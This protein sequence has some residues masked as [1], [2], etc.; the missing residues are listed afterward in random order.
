MDGGGS[1]PVA[2]LGQDGVGVVVPHRLCGDAVEQL[3]AAREQ[4]LQVI[5]QLGHGAHGGARAADRVGLV[6]SDGRRHAV[7]TVHRRFV[8]AVQELAGVGAESLDVT[9][10]AFGKQSVEH[11][12]GLAR[13]TGAGDHRQLAGADVQVHALQVVLAGTADANEAMTIVAKV[14]GMGLANRDWT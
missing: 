2:Q 4:Q 11:Q 13:P 10:L 7:H 8:H 5:V 14:G 9:A 6:D 12:A 1:H 3:C